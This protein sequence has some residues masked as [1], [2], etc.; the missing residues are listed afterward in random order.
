[1]PSKTP[2]HSWLAVLAALLAVTLGAQ[3]LLAAG[4]QAAGSVPISGSGFS[5]S[6]KAV[7]RWRQIVNNH[8]GM[9]MS[10]SPNGRDGF[11]AGQVDF[12]VSDN[13][14]SQDGTPDPPPAPTATT[15]TLD[16]PP[17]RPLVANTVETLTATVRPSSLAGTV[18]FKDGSSNIGGPVA[19][20]GGTAATTT[21]LAPGNHSLTAIFTPTS[22]SD[23]D[24][25]TSP[26][27]S[28]VVNALAVVKATTTTFTVIPSGPVTQGVPIILIAQVMPVNA[29]GT[30]QFMDGDTPLG[31]PRPVF[32][33]FALTV[34]S[35]LTKGIHALTATFAPADPGTFAPSTPPPVSLAVMGL[36]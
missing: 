19:V 25:S 17:D 18:Q 30:V 9:M 16:M 10:L 12:A 26:V 29:A 4:A 28:G 13:G 2:L 32:S 15:I 3:I 33:G 31:T 6:S 35:Q 23:L 20:S 24:A 21:T 1:M 7:H 11:R 14:G 8:D 5:E 27:I 34:T 22:L 36:S